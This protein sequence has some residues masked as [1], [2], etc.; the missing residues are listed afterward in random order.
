M[1]TA[2]LQNDRQLRVA[3]IG[4]GVSGLTCAR[5]LKDQRFAVEVFDKA[6][7]VGGRASTR[8]MEDGST[9]DHGAQYFTARDPRFE[10]QVR[11]WE[12]DGVVARWEGSIVGITRGKVERR[13]E[14]TLR[15]VGTPT[16]NAICKAL[17]QSCD[18]QL[19]ALVGPIRKSKDHWQLTDTQGNEFGTFDFVVITTPP[20]Q[21]VMLLA[22]VPTLAEKAQQVPMKGCWAVMAQ[23]ADRLD[24][25]WDGAFVN[26]SPLSW[27]ARN[28]NKPERNSDLEL[29]VLHASPEWTEARLNATPETVSGDLLQAFQ[30]CIGRQRVSPLYAKAHRW[31]YAIPPE[32]LDVGAIVSDRDRVILCGDWCQGSRVEGAYLSGLAASEAILR[33]AGQ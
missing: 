29:W 17:A 23:F 7:G 30:E 2:H 26:D 9:F 28:S 4:A 1:M 11:Q 32:P 19:E 6:R 31:L 21:A 20:A 24:V 22:E 5:S 13:S 18:V 27:L 12:E 8:R 10:E 16:M 15:Y 3:V 25:S 14:T 33:L